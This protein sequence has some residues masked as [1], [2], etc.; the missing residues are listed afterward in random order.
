VRLVS[1]LRARSRHVHRESGLKLDY[2]FRI[3]TLNYLLL[4]NSLDMAERVG[5]GAEGLS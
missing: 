4:I 3:M 5:F 1:T 2:A